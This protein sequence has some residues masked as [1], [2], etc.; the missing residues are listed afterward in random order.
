MPRPLSAWWDRKAS[1]Y[2][3]RL[4]P[5]SEKTGKRRSLMLCDTKGRP[6]AKGDAKGVAAA[7]QRR[8]AEIDAERGS[9]HPTVAEV[10]QL[11]LD[12]HRDQKSKPATI[13]G[14]VRHLTR[15]VNFRRGGDILGSAPAEEINLSDLTA[16]RR[17]M[18]GKKYD[19][20][21]LRLAYASILA[22]WHWASRPVE[23]RVRD[24]LI[25]SNPFEGLARPPKGRGRRKTLPWP[26]I[27]QLLDFA[28]YRAAHNYAR[29]VPAGKLKALALRLI[30]ES[31][32]RPGEALKLEWGWV[33]LDERVAVIPA[34]QHKTGRRTGRDRVIG[35]TE[36][37]AA[38]LAEA[39]AD[40]AGHPEYVFVVKWRKGA[41]SIQRYGEWVRNL[42]AAA[43]EEGL[44]I[45]E[46]CSAYTLRHSWI[47]QGRQGGATLEEVAAGAGHS[48]A[49]AE[50]T[51]TH[52]EHGHI[53]AIV[54]K[55][56]EAR[57]REG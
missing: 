8:L 43:I 2:Y 28:E 41:P 55:V 53:R 3:V 25:P 56:N 6:L 57:G 9:D 32:C 46:D 38:A 44:P 17:W 12:W 40:P 42:R 21:T 35:L 45:P 7:I 26:V 11:Y 27:K 50:E 51:Y 18:E 33:D 36:G 22:C 30:A 1:R 19:T 29:E 14:H 16:F 34:D 48:K 23:G 49:M 20:G 5:V 52:Y 24:R 13:E 4:G 37:M 31:G 15:W 10:C 47:T 54:D 39:K